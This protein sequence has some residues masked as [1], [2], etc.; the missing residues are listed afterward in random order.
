MCGK[1]RSLN[2]T[3]ITLPQKRRFCMA[4]GNLTLTWSFRFTAQ[5]FLTTVIIRSRST[6]GHRC[7][8]WKTWWW[9]ITDRWA[10]IFTCDVSIDT[11]T[12]CATRQEVGWYV[13]EVRECDA[14]K[15]TRA[16]VFTLGF[17]TTIG[18]QWLERW[19]NVPFKTIWYFRCKMMRTFD[20]S[21]TEITVLITV[22]NGFTPIMYF[23]TNRY[24]FAL[25]VT[26]FLFGL[27]VCHCWYR[28]IVHWWWCNFGYYWWLIRSGR[29]LT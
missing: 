9:N 16:I 14:S 8:T 28:S 5:P 22:T 18:W 24:L 17:R 1:T 4:F 3:Y 26:V 25:K 20:Q 12:V 10:S 11:C 2:R 13:F 21:T 19:I 7:R 23:G 27:I 6:I 29:I 15:L